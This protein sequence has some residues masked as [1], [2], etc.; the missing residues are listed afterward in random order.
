MSKKQLII[1]AVLLLAFTVICF[2][3]FYFS[4]DATPKN[5]IPKA[6]A[7]KIVKDLVAAE[8]N[9]QSLT[10]YLYPEVVKS[11]LN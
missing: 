4:S 9:P 10:A 1:G 2:A 8:K 6:Q 11:N 5:L 3:V 7:S